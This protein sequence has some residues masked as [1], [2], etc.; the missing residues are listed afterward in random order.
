VARPLQGGGGVGDV[1]V[2]VAAIGAEVNKTKKRTG[3][4]MGVDRREK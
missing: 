3:S 4:E 2:N 1:C